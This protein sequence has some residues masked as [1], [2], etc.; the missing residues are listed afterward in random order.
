MRLTMQDIEE[1]KVE[2]AE[3]RMNTTHGGLARHAATCTE[4]IDWENVRIIGTEKGWHQRK[5]LE[6]IESVRLKSKGIPPLNSYN[7]MEQ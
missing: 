6:G 7:Q 5:Y 2:A 1:G 4:E 3:A